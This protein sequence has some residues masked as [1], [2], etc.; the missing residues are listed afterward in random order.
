MN[1]LCVLYPDDMNH[2]ICSD[3]GMIKSNNLTNKQIEEEGVNL[4]TTDF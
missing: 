3:E 2:A 1:L 4:Q